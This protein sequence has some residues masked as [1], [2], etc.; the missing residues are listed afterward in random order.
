M[1]NVEQ[2]AGIQEEFDDLH[3]LGHI[4]AV[5]ISDI[6]QG[7]TAAEQ[8]FDHGLQEQS[9]QLAVP[10]RRAQ[11]QGREYLQRNGRIA[12][13][14]PVEFIDQRIGLAYA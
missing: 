2:G 4:P 11:A 13:R 12:P 10:L 5:Q 8:A 3:I 1:R 6:V 7:H 14:A 9:F